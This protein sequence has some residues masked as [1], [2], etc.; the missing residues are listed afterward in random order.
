[1]SSYRSFLFLLCCFYVVFSSVNA[2]DIIS[3][4]EPVRDSETIFSSGK[5]FKLG[6]FSPGN[7]ANRYVGIMFNLPSPTPTV[8][9]VANRD[10]P[11]H[12]SSGILTIS[13][14]GNLVIL[15]GQKEIIWSSS[16]SNS[17]KNSTAQLLDTGN[18]VLKDSSNGRVLWESFQYPTDSLL[19]HENGR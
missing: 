8:V 9:W 4:S 18:L 3:S 7:S 1:M 2:S 5:R 16:I 15:N 11:L 10:K 12:D 17:V 13:G 19:V 14:D 6:F